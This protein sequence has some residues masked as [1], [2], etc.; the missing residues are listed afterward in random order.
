MTQPLIEF[1]DVHK[2]LGSTHVLR[3]TNL[4]I[5]KGEI[6]TIIGKS[7]TGKSVFFKHVIGLL[8]PDRGDII[9]EGKPMSEMTRAE[10]YEWRGKFSYMFQN[11]ALFDS[12][13]IFENVALPLETYT[14]LRPGEVR[15]VV[16]LK[17]SLVGLVHQYFDPLPC[18]SQLIQYIAVGQEINFL[19][20]EIHRSFHE[21]PQIDQRLLQLINLA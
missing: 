12:M 21:N 18:S 17:L 13:T 11:M 6:T 7:G 16:E 2:T 1:R 9:C 4:K 8:T 15:D 3:G 5:P 10:I 14:G 20:R 19:V